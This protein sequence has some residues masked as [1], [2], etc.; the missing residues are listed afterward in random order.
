VVSRRTLLGG[1]VAAPLGTMFRSSPALDRGPGPTPTAF[2]AIVDTDTEALID[3]KIGDLASIEELTHGTA[4]VTA[5]GTVV[6]GPDAQGRTYATSAPLFAAPFPCEVVWAALSV[7]RL[8]G[9]LQPLS[10]TSFWEVQLRK[11]R[12][13][14]TAAQVIARKTSR[15]TSG[16]GLPAGEAIPYRVPWTFNATTLDPAL[17]ILQQGDM[18]DLAFY[19]YGTPAGFGQPVYAQIRYRPL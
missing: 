14:A 2:R 12:P 1:I 17:R 19:P 11:W 9:V 7:H 3:Q 5:Q 8:S 16:G 4:L 18:L 6:A 13:G 10:N 15:Q